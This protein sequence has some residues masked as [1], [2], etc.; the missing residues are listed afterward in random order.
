MKFLTET[1]ENEKIDSDDRDMDPKLLVS[2]ATSIN[3]IG[4]LRQRAGEATPD[5][6]MAAYKKSLRIKRKILGNDSLSV[7]KTLN[8]IG[9]VYYLKK[10]FE[11]ALPAYEEALA[12]TGTRVSY[13][14]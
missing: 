9:S 13:M 8:N 7:G 4:Y 2:M 5:E 14:T 12:M 10:E 1:A 3:N 6:T 11:G